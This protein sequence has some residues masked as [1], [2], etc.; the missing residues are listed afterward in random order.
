MTLKGTKGSVYTLEER[1]LASGGEGA[2]YGIVGEPG[3]LAKIWL[4][5]KRTQRRAEKIQRMVQAQRAEELKDIA[6]PLDVLSD[7]SSVCGFVM[8][9][10]GQTA[11]LTSF[12]TQKEKEDDK[13]IDV[14]WKR[15]IA[16]AVNLCGIVREIHEMGQCIGDMQPKNFGVDT[17]NGHVYAYDADSFHFKAPNGRLYP[18]IVGLPAY[19]A[20]EIQ[21]YLASGR[22]L[23]TLLGAETFTQQTDNWA[24]AV[25]IF[26]LLFMGYH[27][28]A[29][30]YEESMD[31]GIVFIQNKAIL[32]RVC[33]VFN[34]EYKM[35]PPEG[36]PP[37]NIIPN[38]M[39]EMFKS[40]LITDSRPTPQDWQEAL[41]ELLKDTTTCSNGHA[42]W[43]GR[44]LVCP[45]CEAARKAAPKLQPNP[46]PP[47]SEEYRKEIIAPNSSGSRTRQ[48][49]FG[50]VYM[51]PNPQPTPG[52]QPG[53][54]PRPAP[55]PKP[56]PQPA[57][58]PNPQPAPQQTPATRKWFAHEKWYAASVI[59]Y[60]V[61]ALGSGGFD[62]L[63]R[64]F[65]D[66]ISIAIMFILLIGCGIICQLRAPAN[67][68]YREKEPVGVAVTRVIIL[69]LGI[70]CTYSG[71]SVFEEIAPGVDEVITMTAVMWG[72]MGMLMCWAWWLMY[73]EHKRNKG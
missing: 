5:A 11:N 54:G 56:N 9:R 17:G 13:Q 58:N 15:R 63:W 48:T 22:S 27:P 7:G 40:A 28:F 2:V 34:P 36:I 10:F 60:F 51:P 52:P 18:C 31:S 46:P 45:W 4:P 38:S 67:R 12:L 23:E 73:L 68:G 39:A 14:S 1:P 33:P 25:L 3:L 43:I 70:G 64:N 55:N 6:W 53:P 24:L 50:R 59:T 29:G 16:V 61:I 41:L 47:I 35:H 57:P 71:F 30:R 26:Q 49:P 69:I 8:R 65:D 62:L 19:Y 32:N 42:Y 21:R 20:P 37:L 44:G 66:A 72:V